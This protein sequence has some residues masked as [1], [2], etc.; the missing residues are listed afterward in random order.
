MRV[1][2]CVS[3][4]SFVYC[5]DTVG[6]CNAIGKKPVPVMPKVQNTEGECQRVTEGHVEND[7]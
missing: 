5:F 4:F 7:C 2:D 1:G 3:S 6:C